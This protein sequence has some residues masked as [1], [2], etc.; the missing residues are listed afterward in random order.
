MLYDAVTSFASGWKLFFINPL[1]PRATYMRRSAKT[2]ISILE[3]IIKKIS[4][5]W[6]DY[7]SV[8]EKSRSLAMS[9]KTTKKNQAVKGKTVLNVWKI[10]CLFSLFRHLVDEKIWK[11]ESF[12]L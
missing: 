3:G 5:E 6:R 7:E 11:K 1:L 12:M 2:L 4:Y 9:R 8:D 10:L